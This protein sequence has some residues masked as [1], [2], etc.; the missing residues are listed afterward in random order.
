MDDAKPGECVA[1]RALLGEGPDKV[2]P[3]VARPEMCLECAQWFDSD[4]T[5]PPPEPRLHLGGNFHLRAQGQ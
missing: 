4:Y 5:S 2:R 1:C 3:S